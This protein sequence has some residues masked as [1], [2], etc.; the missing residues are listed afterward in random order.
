MNIFTALSEP[1]YLQIFNIVVVS[2]ISLHLRAHFGKVRP[3]KI[4][5]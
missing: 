4:G 3:F 2:D 1:N 5:P